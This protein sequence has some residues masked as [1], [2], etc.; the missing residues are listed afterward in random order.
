MR[1]FSLVETL[2]ALMILS[3]ALIG[4]AAVPVATTR[5]MLL[6]EEREKATLL[7]VS[8]LEEVEAVDFA[9]PVPSWVTSPDKEGT[10][11]WVRTVSSDGFLSSVTVN[12]SW[13]GV[14]G[15]K[16]LKLERSYG[17]FSVR[18]RVE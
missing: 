2:I 3:V 4:M 14:L 8:K 6:A 12:V 18:K 1:G 15:P 16:T 5:L 9:A 13:G 11:N 7:A 17:P 10:F